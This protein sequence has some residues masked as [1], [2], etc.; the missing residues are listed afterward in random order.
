ML[1]VAAAADDNEYDVKFDDDSDGD[2]QVVDDGTA[3]AI[4]S[5]VLRCSDVWRQATLRRR[6]RRRRRRRVEPL[7]LTASWTGPR[8]AY[9][10]GSRSRCIV[11]STCTANRTC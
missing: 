4:I 6:R 9:D 1:V 11:Q 3:R 8:A 2:D 7:M 10:N 5:Q